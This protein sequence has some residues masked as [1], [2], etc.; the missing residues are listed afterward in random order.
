MKEDYIVAQQVEIGMRM[1]V[2]LAV[3]LAIAKYLT[4]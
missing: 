4:K 3:L 1:A 2:W